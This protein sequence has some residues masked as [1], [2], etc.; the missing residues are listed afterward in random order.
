MIHVRL[1][2]YLTLRL[3]KKKKKHSEIRERLVFGFSSP[4]HLCEEKATGVLNTLNYKTLFT[5]NEIHERL[6]ISKI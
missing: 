1:M 4:S 5:W 2:Y 6:C 3:F